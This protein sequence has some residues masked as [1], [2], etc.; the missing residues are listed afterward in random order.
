[1]VIKVTLSILLVAMTLFIGCPF[2]IGSAVV[3][4]VIVFLLTKYVDN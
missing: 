1:M 3:L 4:G 2:L